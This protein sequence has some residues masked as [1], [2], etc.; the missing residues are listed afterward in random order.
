MKLTPLAVVGLV[1]LIVLACCVVYEG[2]SLASANRQL[3]ALNASKAASEAQMAAMQKAIDGFRRDVKVYEEAVGT[4]GSI[5]SLAKRI[6][7]GQLDLSVK[8]LRILAKNKPVVSLSAVPDSGGLIQVSSNDG[9]SMAEVAS[10]PGKSRIG[11]R[12]TTGADAS[13]VVHVANYGDEGYYIQ[14]GPTDD[15]AARTDGAGLQILDDGPD[16]LMAQTGGGNVSISTSSGDERGK[17][18][19]WSEGSPKRVIYLSLGSKDISP[20]L[21]VTGASSGG[22][23][24]LVPDRLSLVNR[25]GT[26]VLADAEDADGGFVFVNDKTGARRATMTAG[27]DGHGSITVLGSDN[28]SNTLYPEYNIQRTGAT[29]K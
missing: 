9:T 17:I 4:E 25:D 13:A 5:R 27:N 24:T 20:F 8:S 22:S 29:Q 28:R 11:V 21:S 7:D 6:E 15:P 23:L 26:V 14:R 10:L 18:S 3:N 1:A 16:F 12:A 2:L 19:L